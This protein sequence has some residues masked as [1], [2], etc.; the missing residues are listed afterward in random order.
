M[1]GGNVV[2][3]KIKKSIE[4]LRGKFNELMDQVDDCN[5]EGLLESSR[6]LDDVI[7]EYISNFHNFKFPHLKS[8][9]WYD[10]IA[11]S[12]TLLKSKADI[13]VKYD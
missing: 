1:F 12:Y 13:E 8:N 3:E 2:M 6:E 4:E 11:P 5:K 7:C 9:K 10:R